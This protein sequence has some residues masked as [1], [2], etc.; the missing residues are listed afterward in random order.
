MRE[1]HSVNHQMHFIMIIHKEVH[2]M[3]DIYYHE[4]QLIMERYHIL[5]MDRDHPI[6]DISDL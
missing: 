6:Q 5:L 1:F 3:E 2:H 4:S